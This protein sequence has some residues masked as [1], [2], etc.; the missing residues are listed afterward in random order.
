M[1]CQHWWVESNGETYLANMVPD[2]GSS[3]LKTV[4]LYADERTTNDWVGSTVPT[5]TVGGKDLHNAY[6]YKYHMNLI[7]YHNLHGTNT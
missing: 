2:G 4:K 1:S 5:S 6:R 3:N 7:I